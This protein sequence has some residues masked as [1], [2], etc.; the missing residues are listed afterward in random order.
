MNKEIQDLQQ[1]YDINITKMQK[2]LL[3]IP[4]IILNLRN[5]LLEQEE[6]LTELIK[7][8]KEIET[9]LL[10]IVNEETTTNTKGQETQKY[11]TLLARELEVE[12]RANNQKEYIQVTKEVKIQ[13]KLVQ[14]TKNDIEFCINRLKSLRNISPYFIGEQKPSEEE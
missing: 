11:K 5:T 8:K 9:K 4:N 7:N 13:Q 2:Q 1:D 12:K 10:E 3:L 6:K 14:Q